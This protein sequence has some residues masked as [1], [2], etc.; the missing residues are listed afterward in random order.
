MND[1]PTGLEIPSLKGGAPPPPSR[2]APP[3]PRKRKHHKLSHTEVEH[4]D[5]GEGNWLVS[6]ADMMTLLVGFFVMLT[7]FSTPD[8]SKMERLKQETAKAMG[9]DYKNPYETLTQSLK[10]VLRDFKLEKEVLIHQT[11]DGVEITSRGTVF[12][13]S[14]SSE[15][16]EKAHQLVERIVLTLVHQAKGFLVVVEGHTDDVPIVSQKFPSNWELS[17]S[18]A[19][20]VVRLMETK[21]F[22]HTNLRSIGFADT[23]P[24]VPNRDASGT[25]ITDNQARNRR[26]VIRIKKQLPPRMSDSAQTPSF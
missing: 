19:N 21:G 7:A 8:A 17:A 16:L 24:L 25:A 12:F 22:V 6:Y 2:S 11:D 14:G 4:H 3:A 26:I 18:R 20:S 9:V 1:T 15:M 10:N 5:D 13:D 23:V